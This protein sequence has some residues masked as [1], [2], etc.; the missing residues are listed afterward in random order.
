MTAFLIMVLMWWPDN[1]DLSTVSTRGSEYVIGVWYGYIMD[2]EG[3]DLDEL[4][5]QGQRWCSAIM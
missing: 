4:G 3:Y 1:F 5:L 2:E